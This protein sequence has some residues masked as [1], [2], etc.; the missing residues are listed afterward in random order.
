MYDALI[1]RLRRCASYDP[2]FVIQNCE[3]AAD[4]I[5]ELLA[6]CDNFETALKDSVEE[7]EEL[8]K[9]SHN[10]VELTVPIK[11]DG[12]ACVEDMAQAV[13]SW[14]YKGKTIKEWADSISEPKTNG[15][16]VRT[17]T[18]EE[19]ADWY[20]D[21]FFPC[22]PYCSVLDECPEHDD[23]KICLLEWLKQKNETN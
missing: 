2:R 4:A 5:E 12:F 15:D 16:L 20:F 21:K 14:T 10:M 13:L 23:C 3:E 6:S 19:L 8:Q 1:K 22:A 17:M 18:D 9:Q 7:C 11:I